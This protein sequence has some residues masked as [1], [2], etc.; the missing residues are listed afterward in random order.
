MYVNVNILFGKRDMGT[1][2]SRWIRKLMHVYMDI[3]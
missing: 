3:I 2:G 1:S